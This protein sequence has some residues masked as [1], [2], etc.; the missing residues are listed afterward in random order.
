MRVALG[1]LSEWI[2]LPDSSDELV[3]RLTLGGLEIE[4]IESSGPALEGV[5]VGHVVECG[6]HPD[7]DRLSLCRV[8]GRISQ[9]CFEMRW[10]AVP[11]RLE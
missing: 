2:P 10:L 1:W 3:E 6:P 7:A 9:P 4:G 5:V 8:A 11:S